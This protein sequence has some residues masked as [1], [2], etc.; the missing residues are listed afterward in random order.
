M[1][2]FVAKRVAGLLGFTAILAGTF[3]AHMLRGILE[4]SGT[5]EIWQT[6][7]LFHLLHAVALLALSE[8]H[9][10]PRVAYALI[11]FGTIIFSGSLYLL[12]A[13]NIRWLGAITP[14]GGLGML[15][16]WA[17]LALSRGDPAR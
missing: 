4:K 16:G 9:P 13:T 5:R 10:P 6:G 15:A 12:A 8:W 7:V 17:T 11:L 14:F 2:A 1:R 3:G